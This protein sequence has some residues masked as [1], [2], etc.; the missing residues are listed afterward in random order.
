MINEQNTNKSL[1]EAA[2][3]ILAESKVEKV[4]SSADTE[5][6]LEDFTLDEIVSFMISEDYEALD[7]LSKKTLADYVY[8]AGGDV[9]RRNAKKQKNA[10]A[11][12]H[13]WKST[14]TMSS[15]ADEAPRKDRNELE[16]AGYKVRQGLHA[17]NKEHD[18]KIVNR[19]MGV[20]KAI[21]KLTKESAE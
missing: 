4:S 16:Q 14:T 1:I 20:H 5:Y 6:S 15:D 13:V 10:E 18:R 9:E 8:R 12:D 2:A 3:K 21:K 17:A 7:E 11:A 19:Y